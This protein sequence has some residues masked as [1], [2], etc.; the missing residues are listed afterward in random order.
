MKDTSDI[1]LLFFAR[2]PYSDT[3]RG[4]F[5]SNKLHLKVVSHL[6]TKTYQ[7]LCDVGLP[8]IISNEHT[9]KSRSLAK[10]LS[11]AI[12]EVFQKGFQKVIVVG[13]DCPE[14]NQDTLEIAIQSLREGKN[15]LGPD[16]E[17]GN[18]LIGIHKSE[19]CQDTFE[20]A[21]DRKSNVHERLSIYLGNCHAP[22]EILDRKHDINS[23]DALYNYVKSSVKWNLTYSY[24]RR[25]YFWLIDFIKPYNRY[26]S[27]YYRLFFSSFHSLRGPPICISKSV[28]S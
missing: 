26:I 28:V 24:L 14:L 9:Q 23:Q 8:L 3:K 1:A 13:N 19:F 20:N 21:L 10:N 17:G 7:K 18:Y 16:M 27:R 11:R 5:A 15:V 12:S 22:L 6:H 4:A 25:V 2:S